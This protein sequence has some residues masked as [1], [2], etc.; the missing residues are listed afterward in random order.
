MSKYFGS[1][2]VLTVLSIAF[3]NAM[4]GIILMIASMEIPTP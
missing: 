4:M 2:I 3:G 1:I